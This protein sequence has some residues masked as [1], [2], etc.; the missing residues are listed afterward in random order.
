MSSEFAVDQEVDFPLKSLRS[1]LVPDQLVAFR[2]FKGSSPE[3]LDRQLQSWI[4]TTKS[5]IVVPGPISVVDDVFYI[6]VSYV[7]AS[8]GTTD[9]SK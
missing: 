4:T 1:F 8:E 7:P 9:A 3:D 2:T 6:A 5:I